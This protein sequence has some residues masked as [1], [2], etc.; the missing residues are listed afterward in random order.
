MAIGEKY[1]V[2]SIDLG[3]ASHYLKGDLE[4]VV[5]NNEFGCGYIGSIRIIRADPLHGDTQGI[6]NSVKMWKAL[7]EALISP[8][9][10][11]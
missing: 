4:K 6:L 10:L 1:N 7:W 9:Q 11:P 5:K 3:T 2:N 8:S